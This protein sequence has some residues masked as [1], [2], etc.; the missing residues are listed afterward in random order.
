MLGEPKVFLS[1]LA[2][3]FA[4]LV[5]SPGPVMSALH[6]T[7]AGPS[8]TGDSRG[9]SPRI[10]PNARAARLATLATPTISGIAPASGPVGTSVVVTGTGFTGATAVAFNGLAAASFTVNSDTQ[11]TAVVPAGATSGPITVTTPSGTAGSGSGAVSFVSVGVSSA[12]SGTT[13]LALGLPSGYQAGDL[14]VAWL[15]FADN[16][17]AITGMTGWTELPWSPLDDGVLW[18]ARAFYKIAVSGEVAP[19]V[20]WTNNTKALFETGA[21]RGV[22]QTSPIVASGGALNLTSGTTV[23]GPSVSNPLASAW[24]IGFFTYRT[25][26]TGDKSTSF[27]S[28]TPAGLT[29]RADA[30]LSAAAS[31]GWVN[32]A[33]ADSAGPVTTGSHQYTGAT[34]G[35][36]GSSHKAASLLYVAPGGG[37]GGFTVTASPPSVT[38]FA[39][40]SGP[41]GTSVVVTG[42]GFTG[43]TAVAFNGLA[44]ASFAVNSATQI[45]AVVP[46]G[47]TS[48]PISVTTPAGG[49]V[50]SATSFTV[51]AAAGP[52]VTGFAPA[53]GPVGTSVVVTGTGFT[54]ATAVAFNGLAAASFAV[55]SAT[56]ITAVVPAGA[57]SGPISVTTPAG[58]P[59]AS[60][61]SFTVSAAAGP[62]ITGFAPASGPVGTSVVVTGTGFTGATAVAFNGLAAASFA[63]NSATQITAVVPAG[64]TSGP[65]S[66]TT[67][68][69]GPVASATSFTVSAAAGP[70]VTGFA[71]ASGPVGTSVVV[72][73]TGFTGATAV[74]FNGLA[75]AS[76]AVNSATQITAVVPAGATSGPISVTTPAGGPVASA[77]SF[78]VTA[79]AGPTV[80]GF[81]P[82]SGPVGTSVVVTG[83][84]FTGAT[85][86]AFNGLAAASFAVNSATQITA[87]VPA[88]ATSGPISVTT[89]S[90]TAASG[91]GGSGAV[92]F[93]SVGVA[94]VS[95]GR[96]SLALTLP[97]GYQAGDLLVAWLSFADNAQAIT[98]M[99]GWTELPWSPLDDGTRWHARGFYKIAVS[100]EVAPTVRWTN[101][102][103]A[104]FETGAW[105]GVAQASPIVASGGALDLTSS[106][107]VVGPSVSNPLASAW[108]IG[109]FTFRT[110]ATGDKAKSFSSFTPAG[111]TKRADANLSAASSPAFLDVAV[112]D[113]AGPVATGAHKYTGVT[114]AA[115]NSSHKGAALLYAAPGGGSGGFTVTA[116]PPSVTGFAPASGPV[117]TSVVV[118]GTGFTGAT[119]VAFN[120]LAA[121]SFAVNSATQ[122]T[123][124]VPAGATSGPITVTT[125]AGAGG[126]RDQLHGDRA[127]SDDHE[128]LRPAAAPWGR[129]WW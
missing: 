42:T 25:T 65:I 11:I 84:G 45:T 22:A 109:F 53:S 52:T 88:G 94:S 26:T 62:T 74:A 102:T 34:T 114:T 75:A 122:I 48:G 125:P 44:A 64:A 23:V 47:A 59:V 31:A 36:S 35:T 104:L 117:G 13:S 69:G 103:K 110:T 41:V 18:H 129:R 20:R 70:T 46:A 115:T 1:V 61:T 19:T 113:S 99:T 123:A 5:I 67:P 121:A 79:A 57:T 60:A 126:E 81:A 27:S 16:A 101:N 86:V 24:A 111:L 128:L 4:F 49:P 124:V 106:K 54:G 40:A 32:V 82:A 89:L 98:G 95:S 76:F 2:A 56:Q 10:R 80:T 118:T 85:A 14:L 15:S 68:A 105:R 78:T 66:V 72:T 63:V 38:G 96:T 58:G 37:G 51:S 90:G 7:Q 33:T 30:N 29:K 6:S 92:S 9:A 120:G 50:A 119:A 28:F 107:N 116:S 3:L 77:T 12:T 83:T 108:A 97:S 39:P 127:A 71:P 100:G 55:N 21:W 8:V 93:V 73:G 112:A 43:A 91:S 87:V 17:Q